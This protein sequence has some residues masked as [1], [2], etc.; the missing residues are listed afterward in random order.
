MATEPVYQYGYSINLT[1]S[2]LARTGPGA[3]TGVIVNSHSSGTIKLWDSLTAANTVIVNTFSFPTGSGTYN[4]FGAKFNV[5]LFATIGGTADITL[6][7]EP[8]NG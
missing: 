6:V 8:Y 5:G 3:V 4:L 1:S 7:F 2:A